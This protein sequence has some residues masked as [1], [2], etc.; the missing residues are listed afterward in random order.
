M[1]TQLV[2]P[3]ISSCFFK[4]LPVFVF[5]EHPCARMLWTCKINPPLFE[6]WG[7]PILSLCKWRNFVSS[8][9]EFWDII[10]S[11]GGNPKNPETYIITF[12]VSFLKGPCCYNSSLTLSCFS[13]GKLKIAN[14][15]FTF[16]PGSLCSVFGLSLKIFNPVMYKF[17]LCYNF[18]RTNVSTVM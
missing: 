11:N 14:L 18:Y 2:A 1:S 9:E 15:D 5:R 6:G 13:I 16:S 10:N 3:K 12:Y 4:P 17:I 8:T 7:G